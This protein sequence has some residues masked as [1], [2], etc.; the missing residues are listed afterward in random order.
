MEQAG[1]RC[2][3]TGKNCR[4]HLKGMRC[5]RGLRGDQWKVYWRSETGGLTRENIEA[6]CL[7]CFDNNFDVP[8]ETVALLVT[9][10][11]SYA[12]LLEEDRRR[13]ITLKS[14][15]RDAADKAAQEFRGR[16]VFDRFDDDVLMEFPS[17][18]DAV[19]AMRGLHIGFREIA[20]R[21]ELEIPEICG[22]IHY[23]EVTRWRN[24]LLVGA[25][26]E[27]TTSMRSLAGL[28]QVVLTEPAAA[29]LK[30][31]LVLEPI[32][33]KPDTEFPIEGIWSLR[34]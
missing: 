20:Q 22:A 4:H 34:L 15:L 18:A 28:N 23:G 31:R 29:P 10:I 14:V 3:C 13:A 32:S 24:G 33:P 16:T 1:R 8:R 2:E 9:D 30:G 19:D 17:S 21:L 5:K 26:V 12:Q 7:E 6:W 25:T 27:L 11:V